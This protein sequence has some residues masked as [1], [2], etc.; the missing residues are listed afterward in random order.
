MELDYLAFA[1]HPDDVELAM[2]GT[3]IKLIN[4]RKTFGVVDLTKGELG[5]RGTSRTRKN[6]ANFASKIMG[7][8]VRENLS[9]KDGNI[10][11]NEENTLKIISCIR[12]YK[13]KIIFAPY[14]NDRHPDHIETS[15]L[16]KHAMFLSGLP[17]VKSK[18]NGKLQKA[19]R[20]K[21]IFYFM[22]TYEFEPTFVIDISNEFGKKMDAVKA[23]KTQFHHSN[24]LSKYPET[25]ISSPEFI[26]YLEARAKVY[27]F[28][29]GKKYGEPFFCEEL[30]ELDLLNYS[31]QLI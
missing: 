14:S 5:T 1:A 3:I 24:T 29:I 31:E 18:L 6:E 16:I 17:K 12:K 19:F 2:G 23:Y 20:P 13:P 8:N 27:G 25:F 10:S 30:I 11:R 4:N 9:I 7:I 21:K 28:K 15:R 26:Q 22:Q